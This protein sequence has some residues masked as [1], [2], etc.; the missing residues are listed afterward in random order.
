MSTN[1]KRTAWYLAGPMSGIPKYN[2]PE[3]NMAS[4]D[5]RRRG[6]KIISPAELD[7]PKVHA[8]AMASPDG[9]GETGHTWG[10]FL[11]RDVKIVADKVQGII[12]LPGWEKSR[13]ARL[14]AFVGLLCGHRF[15]LY[16]KDYECPIKNI[17]ASYVRERVL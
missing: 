6:V 16:M 7:D 5:L 1:P 4:L 3:F 8:A 13:G 10:E 11:A 2:I 17:P 15:R 9:R 14:E 12:F